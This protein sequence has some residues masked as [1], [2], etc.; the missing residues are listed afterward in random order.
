MI[1]MK[2]AQTRHLEAIK[3]KARKMPAKDIQVG[4]NMSAY[5]ATTL[6][7]IQAATQDHSPDTSATLAVMVRPCYIQSSVPTSDD[8]KPPLRKI[9]R[10]ASPH[11]SQRFCSTFNF[12]PPHDKKTDNSTKSCDR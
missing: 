12:A 7:K 8:K 9:K 2:A 10:A 4:S 11:T 3:N 1:V 6:M 5:E